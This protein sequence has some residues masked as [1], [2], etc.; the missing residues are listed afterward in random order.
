MR[1]QDGA[2]SDKKSL[3]VGGLVGCVGYVVSCAGYVVRVAQAIWWVA[4]AMWSE[5]RRLCGGSTQL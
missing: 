1:I 4:Q 2:E 5:L 3:S